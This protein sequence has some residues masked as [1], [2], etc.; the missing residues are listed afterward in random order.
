MSEKARNTSSE[1]CMRTYLVGAMIQNTFCRGRRSA[2]YM[3]LGI[4]CRWFYRGACV[5]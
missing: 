2:R 4:A 1:D 3:R 5:F